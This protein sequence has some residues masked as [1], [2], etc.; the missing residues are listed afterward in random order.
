MMHLSEPLRRISPVLIALPILG[1]TATLLAYAVNIP[2]MDDVESFL[3]FITAY[4]N[5]PT[6]SEKVTWLFKPNNEHRILVAKLV[7]V[8]MHA[9]T[10][11]VNFRW[12]ILAAYGFLLGILWILYRVFRTMKLPLL[13]FLPVPLV[14]LQPQ[15]H[16][17]SNWA[18]TGLQHEVTLCLVLAGVYLLSGRGRGRFAGAIGLQLLASFSMS[19]GLFGWIAGGSVLFAR[20]QFGKLAIWLLF[21]IGAIWYYFYDFKGAQGNESSVAFFLRYP[22]LTLTG[23]FTFL[24]GLFDFTPDAPIFRRSLLPTLA[25][26]VLVSIMVYRLVRLI[27]P[28][29]NNWAGVPA[30]TARRQYFFVGGYTFL[31]VTA[32]I[33]AFLR[34]RFG[35]HVMLVSNYTI[36]PALL[37]CLLYLH[38]LGE[39]KTGRVVWSR[40]IAGTALGVLVSGV[41]YFR[42]L[43][44]MAE[45][46]LRLEAYAFNQKYNGNGLGAMVGSDYARFLQGWMQDAVRAGIYTYPVTDFETQLP[47]S[48]QPVPALTFD[49]S[50]EADAFKVSSSAYGE[51]LR[52]G[53]NACLIV[54]SATHTYLFPVVTQFRPAPFFLKRPAAGLAAEV[55][56]SALPPGTYRLGLLAVPGKEPVRYSTREIAVR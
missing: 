47:R 23:F 8:T 10:G 35:Y 36:Y 53:Q 2:W 21:G 34:P 14:L 46:K 28:W 56:K 29:L 22:Y 16:L 44:V 7:T 4:L 30:E 11:E 32:V 39:A 43:P 42:H 26:L 45:R 6:L 52:G 9:L 20:R 27:R 17:T 18:V 13:A 19:N 25:G 12:L 49:V 5:A 41:M 31:L 50:E 15:Y 40:V 48:A 55:L 33:I 24:G 51:P 38:L 3:G 1:F 37:V 54:R